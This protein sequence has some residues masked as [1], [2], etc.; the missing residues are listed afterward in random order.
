MIARTETTRIANG[1]ANR[2]YQRAEESG[3]QIEKMWLSARDPS[4]RDS[5]ARLDGQTVPA[6]AVFD[7][8]G[9]TAAYPGEFGTGEL[10]INCRCSTIAR[11][12]K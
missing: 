6:K 1:A 8:D 12:A 3:I 9:A 11:V 7:S 5:H 10:D 2:A 4:V